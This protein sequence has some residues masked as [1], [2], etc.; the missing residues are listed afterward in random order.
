MRGSRNEAGRCKLNE[1]W[2]VCTGSIIHAEKNSDFDF[3]IPLL[4]GSHVEERDPKPVLLAH[5]VQ[6]G[7]LLVEG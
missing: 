4:D 6:N 5:V 7:E 3:L 2:T 1:Y